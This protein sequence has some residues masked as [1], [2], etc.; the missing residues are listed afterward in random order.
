MIE[1][2]FAVLG[3][4]AMAWAFDAF[5]NGGSENEDADDGGTDG[6]GDGGTDGDGDGGDGDGGSNETSN[7]YLI[8]GEET[9][10]AG[11][12]NDTI[13]NRDPN[14]DAQ[15]I[16]SSV[17]YAGEG[18]D[19]LVIE[20]PDMESDYTLYGEDGDDTIF[21]SGSGFVVD[22]GDGNDFVRGHGGESEISGGAGDDDIQATNTGLGDTPI[23][24][25]G[26]I[27][28]DTLS[29][30]GIRNGV[31]LISGISMTGGAGED[32]FR[33]DHSGSSTSETPDD[34]DLEA[35]I[36]YGTITDFNP[37]EDVLEVEYSEHMT[38]RELVLSPV[39]SGEPSYLLLNFDDGPTLRITLL[40]IDAGSGLGQSD[41]VY[42]Q[43]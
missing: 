22:A 38:S 5:G 29:V 19:Y 31:D 26:G 41:I 4:G 9:L 23:Y 42:G 28:N 24:V 21:A 25:D 11:D 34:P 43:P 8:D 13:D 14:T 27:G 7:E 37:S 10:Y 12:G 40:G 35:I 17:I 16:G 32:T 15:D 20:M 18:N 30:N 39:G 6:N 3:M 36:D 1:L 2:M 33:V